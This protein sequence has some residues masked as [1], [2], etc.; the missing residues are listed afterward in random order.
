[1]EPGF[2]VGQYPNIRLRPQLSEHRPFSVTRVARQGWLQLLEHCAA[3]VT[4]R[5]SGRAGLAPLEGADVG[6][7]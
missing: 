5:S 2:V 3:E 4:R 1:M 6:R 7:G